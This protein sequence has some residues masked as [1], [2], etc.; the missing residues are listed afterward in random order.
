MKEFCTV[1]FVIKLLSRLFK[2]VHFKKHNFEKVVGPIIKFIY[3]FLYKYI[4]YIFLK[5]LFVL[6]NALQSYK[7]LK[8]FF[9]SDLFEDDSLGGDQAEKL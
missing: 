8:T 9:S 5:F 7:L 3:F 4:A 2:N 6:L 1:L